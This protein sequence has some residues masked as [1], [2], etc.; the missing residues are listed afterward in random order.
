MSPHAHSSPLFKNRAFFRTQALSGFIAQ[1]LLRNAVVEDI[2][3]ETDQ[4]QSG[5]YTRRSYSNERFEEFDCDPSVSRIGGLQL[6]QTIHRLHGL[7][8]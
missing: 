3:L 7:F 2:S 4:L 8:K 1:W 6:K 5:A